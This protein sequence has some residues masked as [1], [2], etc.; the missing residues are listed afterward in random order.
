MDRPVRQ[1]LRFPPDE[2]V[3][4]WIDP[5]VHADKHDFKPTLA[6][7]VTDE[8]LLGCGLIA[9][10]RDWLGEGSECTV[11]VGKLAPLKARICWKRELGDGALRLGVA[12]LDKP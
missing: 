10:S 6:A 5:N 9:L 1:C 12:Y 8:A 2:G 3:V 4:A 11:R 7:L